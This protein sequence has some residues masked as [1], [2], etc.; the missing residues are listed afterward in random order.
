MFCTK[1]INQ[2]IDIAGSSSSQK[3]FDYYHICPLK[4]STVVVV[5]ALLVAGG[6]NTVYTRSNDLRLK[7]PSVIRKMLTKFGGTKEL[8]V[9]EDNQYYRQ[10]NDKLNLEN[11]E[12]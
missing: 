1:K 8:L 7:L 5:I 6:N 12:Q 11:L 2:W 9:Y 10:N 4:R 3:K